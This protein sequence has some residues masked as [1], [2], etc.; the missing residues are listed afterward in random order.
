MAQERIYHELF[1]LIAAIEE[2]SVHRVEL[3]GDLTATIGK[4]KSAG[5]KVPAKL[6]ALEQALLQEEQELL[7]ENM[8]I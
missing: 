6:S 4:M 7:F 8:P 2:D 1:E 5:L 3:R